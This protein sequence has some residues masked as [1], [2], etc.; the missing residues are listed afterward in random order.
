MHDLRSGGLAAY[1]LKR[2]GSIHPI[3]LPKEVL[4]TETGIMNPSI[5]Q[6]GGKI[7]LNVRHINYILY[8]SETKQF[9]HAWGPLVYIHPENDVSLSTHNVMCELDENMNVLS[10][11]RVKMTLDTTPTWNFVGLEDARL[12]N[13]DDRMFLCGVRRDC[14]D[15]KGTGRMEMCEIELKDGIWT[16]VSRNPIPAPGDDSSYC[17]K[18]WMPVLDMPWHF[19][20]WCNPTQVIHYDIENKVTTDAILDEEKKYNFPRDIRGGSQVIRI[21]ENQRMAITHETNLWRDTFGRKD[22]NY[23]HRI[24]VWDNDW[25]IVYSSKEFHFMGTHTDIVSGQEYNIEFATGITFLGG[26]ILISFGLVDNASYILRMPR[27]VFF[28]FMTKG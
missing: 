19:V 2:G 6:Y 3:T 9:P 5:F 12:F 27:Q 1:A 20:K 16:E 23:A 4:G 13:W 7:Y 8:H 15:D 21:N 24:I 18:N 28:D 22:G 10:S 11:H 17:E 25:N 14:Y 26:D